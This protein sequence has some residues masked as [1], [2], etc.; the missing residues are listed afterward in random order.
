[1]STGWTMDDVVATYVTDFGGQGIDF[2]SSV[3]FLIITKTGIKN[4]KLFAQRGYAD[5]T[6]RYSMILN[7]NPNTGVLSVTDKAQYTSN[8]IVYDNEGNQIKE[9]Q[10]QQYAFVLGN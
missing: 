6:N 1:M 8:A 10:A 5:S 3:N 2:S 7:N 9:N 4:Y